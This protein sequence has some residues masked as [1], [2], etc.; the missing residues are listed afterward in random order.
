MRGQH[1]KVRAAA[2]ALALLAV[3]APSLLPA[4]SASVKDQATVRVAYPIQKGITD[5]DG[6]GRYTGYTYEFLEEVAQY[7]GWD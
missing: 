2:L 3:L 1:Q 4:A 5:K 6:E 7:T